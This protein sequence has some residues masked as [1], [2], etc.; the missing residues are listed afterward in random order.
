MRA[1]FE[2]MYQ[3]NYHHYEK[4][5]DESELR[6]H[7]SMHILADKDEGIEYAEVND[8]RSPL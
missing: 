6:F 1:L 5:E 8:Q 2:Y 3:L 7:T 4:P